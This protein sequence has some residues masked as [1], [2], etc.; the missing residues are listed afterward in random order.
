MVVTTKTFCDICGKE[1]IPSFQLT[2]IGT[3]DM[4]SIDLYH[5]CKKKIEKFLKDMRKGKV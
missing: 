1:A 5:S 4:I 2:I 3:L